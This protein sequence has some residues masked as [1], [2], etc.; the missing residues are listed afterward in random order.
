MRNT[1]LGMVN[2]LDT[3]GLELQ[4]FRQGLD[5]FFSQTTSTVSK[6]I[7]LKGKPNHLFGLPLFNVH[8]AYISNMLTWMET[9]GRL[10]GVGLQLA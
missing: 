4:L 3:L 10:F 9:Y 1:C 6:V 2:T 5:G 7:T 8:I